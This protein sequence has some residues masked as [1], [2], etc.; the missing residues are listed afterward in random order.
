MSVR[1]RGH[2]LLCLMTYV[3]RG[4]SPAFTANYDALVIRLDA[5]EPAELVEGPDDICAPMLG[6][7][8]HHCL[9][10]SVVERDRQARAALG[11][12]F[13]DGFA[14]GDR[15]DLSAPRLAAMRA[16]FASGASRAACAGCQWTRLC[17]D[18]AAGGFRRVRLKGAAAESGAQDLSPPEVSLPSLSQ[19]CAPRNR[20]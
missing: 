18:I 16:A 2:H 7:A 1:L 19:P 4:Y 14:P 5:G 3:G 20:D 10:D 12:L 15:L 13:G 11:G 6:E 9:N 17:D 8:G